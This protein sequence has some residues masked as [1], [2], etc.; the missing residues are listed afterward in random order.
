MAEAYN[1]RVDGLDA[2]FSTHLCFSDYRL[3]FPGLA[4]MIGCAQFAVG[5]AND[6]SRELGISDNARPGHQIIH[7]YCD[8]PAEPT[9]GL[10]VLDVHTDFVEPPELVQA[11][12]LYAANVFGGPERLQIMP[13]CGLRTGS[14]RPLPQAHQ[15]GRRGYGSPAPHWSL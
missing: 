4:A 14:W 1:S 13:E 3:C 8:L 9:L 15:H 2:S 12:I 10:G 11:W 7:A 6:D 5:F